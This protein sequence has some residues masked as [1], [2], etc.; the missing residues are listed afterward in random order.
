MEGASK[1]VTVLM[2]AFQLSLRCREKDLSVL[3]SKSEQVIPTDFDN[4]V[5][6][7]A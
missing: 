2:I 4:G 5:R 6:H 3:F 7:A 1:T